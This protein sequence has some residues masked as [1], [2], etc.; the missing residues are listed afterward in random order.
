MWLAPTF[1]TAEPATITGGLLLRMRAWFSV[2][3]S[4][5]RLCTPRDVA[6]SGVA[7]QDR[8]KTAVLLPF[9]IHGEALLVKLAE[10]LRARL[11]DRELCHNPLLLTMSRAPRS[12]LVI[13]RASYIEFQPHRS[14]YH[15]V[16]EAAPDTTVTL[17]TADFDTLVQF[18][19]Q[20]VSGG[21][22]ERTAVGVAS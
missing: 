2:G 9:P 17:D 10:L 18:V 15:V 20:Y 13:D 12:R 8:V 11:G 22:S 3:A 21:L 16:V 14:S 5:S 7:Q 19:V 1:N 6:S 4:A